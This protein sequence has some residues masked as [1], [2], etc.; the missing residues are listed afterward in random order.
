MA[1]SAID[2]KAPRAD[3]QRR[4]GA[5]GRTAD[6]PGDN[7][8]DFK[9]GDR[10]IERELVEQLGVSRHP[11]REALRLLAREGFVDLHRNRGAQ[12]SSVDASSVTEV[13]AIRKALGSLALDR[14]LTSGGSVPAADL[15]RLETLMERADRCAKR[16]QHDAAIDADLD[17]QQA[18]RRCIGADAGAA[19]L[20]GIL[21][22]CPP[23]QR[24]AGNSLSAIR[25]PM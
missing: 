17:F 6:P 18:S 10:L 23:L 11:V 20:R 22:R 25:R 1:L 15:K 5:A 4:D 14:L 13:Y 19:L 21:R 24:P 2:I 7:S 16:K 3:P 9:P 12:V 8:G